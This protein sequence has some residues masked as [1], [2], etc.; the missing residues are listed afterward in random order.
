MKQATT[1]IIVSDVMDGLTQIDAGIVQC[2]V[3]S[4]PYW[5]LRD[6]GVSGQIG[7]EP[8]PE[9][10]IAKMVEVF[11]EVRRV[12]R[13][14]GVL[15]L[16]LGDS[17]SGGG[18]GGNPPG[19]PYQKQ[20]TNAGCLIGRQ[21]TQS[22]R[23]D[24]AIIP[25]S[26]V[27]VAG[28]PAKNL[29]GIPWRVA[30][31][32]QDDGWILRSAM[33]W[34]K[35]SA[36][37][38]SCRDRPASALEY[39]FLLTKS[40]RY[41]WDDVAVRVAASTSAWP[42]IGPKHAKERDR[43]ERYES[44]QV[45]SGRSFR[46]TDLFYE[47]LKPPHGMIHAG[48]EPVGLD[49]TPRA[50]NA[51]TETAR[52]VH[53]SLGDIS[54]D[55]MR[56]TSPDCPKHGGLPDRVPM[57]FRGGRVAG[58]L[59]RTLRTH[60]RPVPEREAGS[61][62]SDWL[63]EHCSLADGLDSIRRGSSPSAM[64]HSK[65]TRRTDRAP[66]TSPPYTASVQTPDHTDSTSAPPESSRPGASTP[67]SS[68][69]VGSVSGGTGIGD[70]QMKPHNTDNCMCSCEHYSLVSEKTAH[71]A[72]YPERLVVPLMK[73]GT[74]KK[75]RCPKCGAPWER[76]VETERITRERPNDRTARH[77][78]GCGVNSCGNTVAGVISRTN[79]WQST[80]RCGHSEAE[81]CVVLDP[82]LGSG[83]TALVANRLGRN[84]IGIELNP[85]YAAM[86][87]HRIDAAL[88]PCTHRTDDI[89]DSPLFSTTRW[90]CV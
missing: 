59:I 16:N 88:H 4:P 61:D 73:A 27:A 40:S 14:D 29:L 77:N 80:C 70:A 63:R 13:D 81:P 90:E 22:R 35:R 89:G 12:L 75:G 67:A 23:R 18:R 50:F 43:N 48:D 71:F 6:Y 2:V 44:M 42:G 57:A 25:R 11:G 33:P 62:L 20:A 56:I 87:R 53:V 85:E 26:D 10:F 32:L 58:E 66:E 55:M 46:N 19:S 84:A 21:M 9:A 68:T 60:G 72:T 51:S 69:S 74:S 37:P 3:T 31:A 34:V 17:Y 76:I 5:G 41:F 82:F 54:D 30:L 52:L 1:K 45:H 49:V 78:E 39:V 86:A 47:S 64:P 7:S 24:D 36:M 38:E 15:L 65:R 83:T 8:T 79:G 28:L